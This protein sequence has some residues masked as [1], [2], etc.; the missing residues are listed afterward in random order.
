MNFSKNDNFEQNVYYVQIKKSTNI[1]LQFNTKKKYVFNDEYDFDLNTLNETL[2]KIKSQKFSKIVNVKNDVF[3]NTIIV[4]N[5][6]NFNNSKMNNDAQINDFDTIKL[7]FNCLKNIVLFF[8]ML[9]QIDTYEKINKI[10]TNR[11]LLN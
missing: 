2:N 11:S 3:M 8:K 1:V 9:M 7:N 4:N 6:H 10:S 5:N